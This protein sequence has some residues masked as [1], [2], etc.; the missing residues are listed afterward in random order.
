MAYGIDESIH[1]LFI[2]KYPPFDEY[3]KAY[4]EEEK[5]KKLKSQYDQAYSDYLDARAARMGTQGKVI[6]EYDDTT[7]KK[8]RSNKESSSSSYSSFIQRNE[9]PCCHFYGSGPRC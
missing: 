4:N 5:E 9:D 2:D 1:K 7:P 3:L 8:A 6:K